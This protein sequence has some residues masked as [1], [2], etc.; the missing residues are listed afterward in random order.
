MSY[1]SSKVYTWSMYN[2][3]MVYDWV[4]LTR[5]LLEFPRDNT[6]LFPIEHR[7]WRRNCCFHILT[8]RG[9]CVNNNLYNWMRA[10]HVVALVLL[11][12]SYIWIYR[13]I[14]KEKSQFKQQ[15]ISLK[16]KRTKTGWQ[17]RIILIVKIITNIGCIQK[18][19]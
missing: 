4:Y 19:S 8:V 9:I 13:V 2:M 15:Y 18:L 5:M 11:Q 17:F 16:N 1:L 7:E 3:Y 14:C 10:V 12:M 6:L